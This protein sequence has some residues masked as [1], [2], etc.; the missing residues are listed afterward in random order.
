V[1]GRHSEVLHSLRPE[2][3]WTRPQSAEY[4]P[5][6]GTLGFYG[7]FWDNQI[8][9]ARKL[10]I[11]NGEMAEWSMAQAWKTIPASYIE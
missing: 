10:L 4:K 8:Q 11:L 5:N 3:I 2:S 1:I 7:A 9:T 6:R